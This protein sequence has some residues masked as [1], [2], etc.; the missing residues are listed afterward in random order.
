[1]TNE[2]IARRFERTA[3][4]MEL[5]GD[6]RYR[7]RAYHNAAEAIETWPAPVAETAREGGARALQEIP[8][9]GRGLAGRVVELVER[10]TFE[11]WERLTAETP[12]T[13]LDLLEVEGVGMKTAAALHQRFKIST[14]EDLRDFAEGGGLDLLDG[15]GE[16]SAERI[17][18]SVNRLT[19][20]RR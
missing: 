4:L 19:R 8:G 10:G 18:A 20:H 11:A 12:E 9:V 7:A 14:L 6:D 13:V 5:R 15:L 2:E 16:K 17:R 1:M 3:V